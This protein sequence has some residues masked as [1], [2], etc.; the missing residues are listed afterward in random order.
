[1]ITGATSGFG[2]A[3]AQR[4]AP[5]HKLILTGRRKERL[6]ELQKELGGEE[7]IQIIAEDIRDFSKM[8]NA[9]SQLSTSWQDV[10]VLINNAGLALGLEAAHEAN[11]DD[12]HTMIDTNVTALVNTSRMILPQMYQKNSGYI[13]N[14]GS[15]AGSWPYPGGNVYGASKAFVQQF[16]RNLRADLVGKN[17]RVTNIEPGLAESEFSIVRFKGNEEKANKVYEN[18]SP[19]LPEDI[20]KT[21]E[22]LI[23]SP[24]HFN[25]N[26]IEI[27]PTGQAWGPLQ[28]K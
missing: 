2:K 9:Y 27:M 18:K 26:S 11:L 21:V 8:Q 7:K 19:L 15:I 3:M 12:W 25:V 17:I 4:L 20:A 13:I 5:H 16:S 10:D 6:I 22:W 24:A 1:M 28:V 14:I 23:S